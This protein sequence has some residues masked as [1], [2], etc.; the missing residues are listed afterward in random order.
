MT[1]SA[2]LARQVRSR[3]KGRCE[4]CQMHESLQGATFHVEH[5]LPRSLG[6]QSTFDNLAWACPSCN[7]HKSD[8]FSVPNPESGERVPL[9]DPRRDSWEIH[10]EFSGFEIIGLTMIG[11]ALIAAFH[12]NHERRQKIRQAEAIFNLFPPES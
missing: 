5:V 7:L 10:L 2:E 4:Y 1:V 11:K 6:G 12:L 8:C 9:F 3:A